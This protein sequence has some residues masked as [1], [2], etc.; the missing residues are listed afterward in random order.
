MRPMDRLERAATKYR[1]LIADGGW[2]VALNL[3]RQVASLALII[4][5][6]RVLSKESVGEYQLIVATIGIA[7][8]FTM[9]GIQNV[10][11]QSIARGFEGTFRLSARLVLAASLIGTAALVGV[12]LFEGT[13]GREQ[14][15]LGCLAAAALFPFAHGLQL[16]TSYNAGH[17]E[18]RLNSIYQGIG[19]LVSYGAAIAALLTMEIGIAWVVLITNVVLA[20]QN[21]W[22]AGR[23]YLKI[24]KYAGAE[25]GAISYGVRTTFHSAFNVAGNH[26][27]KF[28]LFYFLSPEAL[29]VF[30]VAER[31]PELLK[32]YLQ[33]VRKVLV[34]GFSK[35]SAYTP[36]LNRKLNMASFAISAG[37]IFIALAIVPW[38]IPLAFTDSY[39]E[40]TLYCQLLLGT[41]VIG[42]AATTKF[43][44]ILSKLDA[45]SYRD[46]T[47][48]TNVVRL[49]ASA[50]LVPFFGILGAIA[51]T[52]LYRIATAVMVW[53]YLR[54]FHALPAAEPEARE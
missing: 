15:L 10:V 47:V 28:L 33:S 35:R 18:F 40:A 27:D 23:I 14:V 11:T 48:G 50:A 34:P 4:V 41:I 1:K 12:G 46:I 42:Q 26:A 45:R 51:S 16:W 54:K 2:V 32:K 6:V 30:A 3:L 5:M 9:P 37:V 52:A 13:S 36:E 24:S 44:F 38:F 8:I 39:E 20:I 25:P 29:A 43:T 21:L 49:V 17:A 7:G 22:L 53:H 31:I 19:F